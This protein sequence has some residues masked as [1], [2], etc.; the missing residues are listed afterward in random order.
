MGLTSSSIQSSS[1]LSSQIYINDFSTFLSH[2][3]RCI[4]TLVCFW[5][6]IWV[7]FCNNGNTF[8]PWSENSTLSICYYWICSFY[9]KCYSMPSSLNHHFWTQLI[10]NIDG[11]CFAGS[12]CFICNFKFTFYRSFWCFIRNESSTLFTFVK[13]CWSI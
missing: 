2:S 9:S 13:I 6:C 7:I 8:N 5:S 10:N 4:W 11:S 1:I 3:S 12:S